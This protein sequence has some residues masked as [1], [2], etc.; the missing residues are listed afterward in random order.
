MWCVERLREKRGEDEME[1]GMTTGNL[2]KVAAHGF[3]R[4]RR[5]EGGREYCEQEIC[6]GNFLWVARCERISGRRCVGNVSE[7]NKDYLHLSTTEGVLP[8]GLQ[9]YNVRRTQGRV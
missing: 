9:M 4:C 5:A 8:G 3:P 2:L 7:I 1:M 6:T